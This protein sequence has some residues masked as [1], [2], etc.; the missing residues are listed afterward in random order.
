MGA[1]LLVVPKGY[2]GQAG[3]MMISGTATPFYMP[4]DRLDRIKTISEVEEL[5]PQIY[6]ETVSTVCC[7]TE[8]DL[9]LIHI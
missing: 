9:S 5:T 4:M 2:G 6:L 3:E 7:R 8:G 1:D